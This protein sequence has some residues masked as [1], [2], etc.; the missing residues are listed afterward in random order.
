MHAA[1]V[2]WAAIMFRP[3]DIA[4]R[5]LRGPPPPAPTCP[6]TPQPPPAPPLAA[7]AGR[8]CPC[9]RRGATTR[10]CARAPAGCLPTTTGG[11]VPA[12]HVCAPACPCVP[13]RAAPH[14]V[15]VQ[16]SPAASASSR[17]ASYGGC[18]AGV[19]QRV[20]RFL[21]VA[22]AQEGWHIALSRAARCPRRERLPTA[23]GPLA[24]T[25]VSRPPGAAMRVAQLSRA[26]CDPQG[27]GVSF[28][29]GQGGCHGPRRRGSQV[30]G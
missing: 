29:G 9:T 5:L 22:V 4:C 24:H 13:P 14:T 26:P 16:P 17:A 19:R 11:E 27:H 7:P 2:G 20:A 12:A 6:P 25:A 8:A 21:L 3:S 28:Q 15:G 23:R 1:S 18:P 10:C 30:P